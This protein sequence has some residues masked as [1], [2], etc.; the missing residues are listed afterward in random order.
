MQQAAPMALLTKNAKAAGKAAKPAGKHAAQLKGTTAFQ[1]ILRAKAA[2]AGKAGLKKPV[3]NRV[4]HLGPQQKDQASGRAHLDG[5]N[6]VKEKID[7]KAILVAR[8]QLH[9]KTVA[10]ASIPEGHALLHAMDPHKAAH[11]PEDPKK[12]TAKS[13]HHTDGLAVGSPTVLAALPHGV[14]DPPKVDSNQPAPT[15]GVADTAV[16]VSHVT[17]KKA[18]EPRVHVVDLRKKHTDSQPDD[19]SSGTKAAKTQMPDKEPPALLTSKDTGGA[20]TTVRET[21]KQS[22]VP[23]SP[24][25]GALDRLREMAGSELTRA[26]GIILRDGGGE[27]KLTLKP[28]SLGSVRIRMN[29]VDNSI[30]GRIIVDNTAVKHVFEGSLDSLMR[31]LTAEGFQTASLQVSVG[32]QGAD[33]SRQEKENVPRIRRVESRE[34][35]GLDWNVPGVENL[36]LGDLLVNLFV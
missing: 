35:A 4:A 15:P 11:E 22:P 1:S 2:L 16:S 7:A 12:K 14:K 10:A 3:A 9:A 34:V 25:A 28:E 21:Q 24:F 30:E 19:Q 5:L 23:P 26:A 17:S 18:A 29:L 33:A 36:S 6:L 27:I 13:P 8:E 32:G 31:A 20:T